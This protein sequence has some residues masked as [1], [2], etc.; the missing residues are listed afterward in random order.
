MI[1]LKTMTKIKMAAKNLFAISPMAA[2][3]Y[4]R[5]KLCVR[6]PEI[7]LSV[8]RPILGALL[9]TR[10]CNLSC[11]FCIIPPL[12]QPKE[13]QA[14]EADPKKIIQ[15]LGHPAMQHAL[16]IGLSG[17]EPLLNESL[18][19]IVR[20]IR[21]QGHL[22]GVVTN[23]TLLEQY[24]GEL[25]KSGINIINVSLYDANSEK[26]A[27]ILPKTNRTFRCRTNKILRQSELENSPQ[28]I[29]EAIRMSRDAGCY[30]MYLGN[31]LPR[32]SDDSN[33]V[34]FED[35]ARYPQ[36]RAEMTAKYRGFPIYWPTPM[37]RTLM[38]GDKKCRML[39]HYL[40]VDMLGNTGLCCNYST[41]HIG[42][43]GNLFA[44]KDT[45]GFNH[46]LKVAMRKALLAKNSEIPAICHNCPIMC[47]R[48]V[49]DY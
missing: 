4:V 30:G 40:S 44:S 47:D 27:A 31:Y 17:G 49:S 46:P 13:W 38:P 1:K 9:V 8:F 14:Y 36:F 41:D 25:K 10:R 28:K 11:P 26:L 23:G 3:N 48:W 34:I 7:D 12:S 16:Y 2:L 42:A 39:W 29:E 43:Y 15:I 18:T 32:C 6:R 24:V 5:Y 20:L 35:N 37:K 45:F 22:C 19:E 33:E 21:G